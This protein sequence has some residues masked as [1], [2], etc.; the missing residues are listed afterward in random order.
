[1]YPSSYPYLFIFLWLTESCRAEEQ[2]I[3]D[4]PV[5]TVMGVYKEIDVFGENKTVENYFGI[6]YAE[7]PT[8][9]LRFK[10]SVPRAQNLTSPFNATKH[11]NVC[12]RMNVLPMTYLEQSED[13]LFLNIYVPANRSSAL[14]VMVFIH[15]GSFVTLASDLFV[16]NTLASFGEVIVATFNYR[17]SIFGW[18]S[19]EDQ[20]APGNYGFSDQHLAIKWVRDNIAAFGGDPARITIFGESAG[21]VSVSVQSLYDGN[22]GLFQR[23]IAQSG[24]IT[25][26]PFNPNFLEPKK[27]ALKLG[28]LVGCNAIGSFPLVRC[29]RNKTADELFEKL[30][31]PQNGFFKLPL[32]F[33]FNVVDGEFL[34]DHPIDL[35]HGDSEI[36]AAG[37]SFFSSIDFLSG[38][39]KKEGCFSLPETFELNRLYY[40]ETLVPVA[41]AVAFGLESTKRIPEHVKAAVVQIYTNWSDPD[42]M[43]EIRNQYVNLLTEIFFSET[44]LE[45]AMKHV[46][47]AQGSANTF[48]YYFD[49]LPSAHPLPTP[50][51]CDRASHGDEQIY[52][53]FEES[54]GLMTFVPGNEA[55]EPQD[56]ERDVAKNIIA[57]WTNFAKSG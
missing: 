36:S 1:M 25:S 29:L 41:I 15:G 18:L 30:N 40:N 28:S 39:N 35:L 9:N 43:E 55:W 4:T 3:V 10:N 24:S 21:G 16:S 44:Q 34:K 52:E 20:H 49:I 46:S 51:W 13:C 38:F 2:P 27:D 5:G 37:R 42:L 12:W 19:T 8:G 14:A 50:S 11:G 17:L 56:W 6:P 22:Q 57:M 45:A 53:F 47:L 33:V 48:L 32:P 31:D 23:A 26:R 54:G 7:P